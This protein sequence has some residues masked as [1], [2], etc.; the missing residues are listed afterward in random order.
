MNAQN[1]ATQTIFGQIEENRQ[2]SGYYKK[3]RLP[4][5][6]SG[7]E[8][9]RFKVG[10]KVKPTE[11]SL[12]KLESVKGQFGE[13]MEAYTQN[14]YHYYRVSWPFVKKQKG[15]E[16]NWETERQKDLTLA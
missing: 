16:N 13:V 8:K 11:H 14:G 10:D 5:T 1:L 7:T 12:W 3:L 2:L 15:R 4:P 9:M 6:P